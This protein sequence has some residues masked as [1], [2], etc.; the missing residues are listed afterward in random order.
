MTGKANL[1]LRN[2]TM[3]VRE[4]IGGK[5]PYRKRESSTAEDRALKNHEIG[6]VIEKIALMK[7]NP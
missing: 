6:L 3:A 1:E 2:S 5:V 4:N 7:E